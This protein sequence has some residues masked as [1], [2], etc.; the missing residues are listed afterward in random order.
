M[1]TLTDGDPTVVRQVFAANSSEASSLKGQKAKTPIIAGSVCA[2]L[3]TIGWSVALIS[4]LIRRRK[5]RIRAKKVAAGVKPPK[6]VP[7]PPEKYV[8]PPDPA[9]L[10]GQRQPGE[11]VVV[12][13]KRRH[14]RRGEHG[15]HSRKISEIWVPDAEMGEEPNGTLARNDT[16]SDSQHQG[17]ADDRPLAKRD[18]A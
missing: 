9:V 14:H 6:P 15:K 18:I 4:Y 8:I 16:E 1:P 10:Y 12:E 2:V 17:N 11:H 13:S 3:L 5:K 7:Q